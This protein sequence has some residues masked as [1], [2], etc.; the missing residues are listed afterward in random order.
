MCEDL[1]NAAEIIERLARENERLLCMVETERLQSE[2]KAL[3]IRIC[4]LESALAAEKG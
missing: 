1:P 4:E 2:V 3:K